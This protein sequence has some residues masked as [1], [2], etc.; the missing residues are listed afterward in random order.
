MQLPAQTLHN[1][2]VCWQRLRLRQ[3]EKAA[4]T[5]PQLT[6]LALLLL[7]VGPCGDSLS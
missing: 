5:R 1:A 7:V 3:N 4:K 2:Q 6:F